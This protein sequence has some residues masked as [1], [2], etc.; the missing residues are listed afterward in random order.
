MSGKTSNMTEGN[1]IRILFAFFIPL[2]LG[3]LFQQ[4]YSVVDS[5]IVGK[6]IGDSALAAVGSTGLINFLLLGFIFGLTGGFGIHMSQSFGAGDMQKLR[7][8]IVVASF[9]SVIIGVISTGLC[10][11]VVRP[12][13]RLVDTPADIFE[14]AVAYFEIILFGIIISLFCNLAY[15]ILRAVGNSR[16]PLVATIISSIVNIVLDF[17]L[18][19]PLHLGV[20]GAALATVLSQVMSGLICLN[21]IRKIEVLKITKED[22]H[23]AIKPAKDMLATGLPV[24]I[25]NAITAGG[26]LILQTLVNRMGSD[27]VA[28]YAACMKVAGLF[29]QTGIAVGMTM[30]TYVGQNVGAGKLDRVKEGIRKGFLL[31]TVMNV[32]LALAEV[33]FPKFLVGIMLNSPKIIQ[34]SV[35]FLPIT[36]IGIFALGYLFVYRF[37]LQGLGNTFMPMLSGIVE[38]LM[39]FV[40]GLTIGVKSFSGI[41][42]S[43]VSAW[44]G[45]WLFLMFSYFYVIRK[46]E[47]EK[48]LEGV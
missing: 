29:E 16:T 10:L 35:E 43:E 32:P 47:R 5:I 19:I 3:N 45:A 12:I 15:T 6:G 11:W 40:F 8:L 9:L 23:F 31:S 26:C 21:T 22:I 36:G 28:S 33:L 46:M 13:F 38:V 34:T 42:I 7:S 44:V 48:S 20:R 25:M 39:R 41:A 2:F 27:Y 24:G 4:A 30:I 18:V 17:V 37:S 1:I 14:D